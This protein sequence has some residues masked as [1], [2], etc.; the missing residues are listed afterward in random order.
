MFHQTKQP[1]SPMIFDGFAGVDQTRAHKNEPLSSELVNFRI[2]PD[3]SIE[4]RCGYRLLNEFPE[5]IRAFWSGIIDGIPTGF[6][7]HGNR[8]ERIR[9]TNGETTLLA[10]LTTDTGN[11]CLFYWD[12]IL[13]L[14]DSTDLYQYDENGLRRVSG[15]IP[16]IGKDWIN[17]YVGEPYEPMNIL[18][19]RV[20]ISY[21]IDPE[22]VSTF[23]CT[24]EPVESVEAVFRNGLRVPEDEYYIY[25]SFQ[26][27]NVRNVEGNDRIVIYM[28]LKGE[29]KEQMTDLLHCNQAMVFESPTAPRLFFWDDR[30]ISSMICSSYVEKSRIEILKSQ[31]FAGNSLYI[32]KGYEFMVGDGHIRIQGAVRQQDDLLI[33]TEK[34]T[35]KA[36]ALVSGKAEIPTVNIHTDVGCTSPSG[37]VLADNDPVVFDKNSIRRLNQSSGSAELYHSESI[38]VPIEP[39]LQ[40]ADST[41]ASLFYHQSKEELWLALPAMK[42]IWIYQFHDK[43]WFQFTGICAYRMFDVNGSVG[44]LT[45]NGVF[46]LDETIKVDQIGRDT[47]REIVAEAETNLL[48]FGSANKKSLSEVILRGDLDKGEVCVS[49]VSPDLPSISRSIKGDRSKKH[50]ILKLRLPSGRFRSAKIALTAKGRARQRIHGMELHLHE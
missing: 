50:S 8:L 45:Q 18:S 25:E 6:V 15:Y 19:R 26:T 46:V 47:F 35:W 31:G 14:M 39:L 44:F 30:Q 38:S 9:L 3:G 12:Q 42:S 27:I 36:D 13:H 28:T 22:H 24:P 33:F 37:I 20:R 11:A 7:V 29:P 5:E 23:L 16:L 4:K 10:T 2:L 40:S 17:N 32:P 43:R 49:L 41:G 21:I 48:D 1:I 34:S